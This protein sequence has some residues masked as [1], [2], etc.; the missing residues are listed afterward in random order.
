MDYIP[1]LL[2]S[3]VWTFKGDSMT[4]KLGLPSNW[5]KWASVSVLISCLCLASILGI[6]NVSGPSD[7]VHPDSPASASGEPTL[8]SIRGDNDHRIIP[9]EDVQVGDRVEGTNPLREQVE[10]LE[11][12]AASWRKLKL[13]MEKEGGSSLSIDLLRSLE[14]IKQ[15]QATVGSTIY[16]ELPEM[17]AVGD[18]TVTYLGPCPRIKPGKGTPVTGKFKHRADADSGVVKLRLE[19]QEQATGVTANH[20]YWSVKRRAFAPVGQLREGEIVD[21]VLGE[22]RVVSITPV[23]Y[24]GFLYNLETLEHVFRVDSLGTLVHNTCIHATFG[25]GK[26]IDEFTDLM[27]SKVGKSVESFP[28]MSLTK[29][30]DEM[31]QGTRRAMDDAGE[32][33]FSLKGMEKGHFQDFVRGG[34]HK[35]D[36]YP[37]A[38]NVTDRELY[39]VLT[40]E[41]LLKKATFYDELGN[42]INAPLQWLDLL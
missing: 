19:G 37:G 20:L 34:G 41:N 9:I 21:T 2:K 8:A 17:G 26:H 22:R 23:E 39:E 24:T 11:L 13:H 15:Q 38:S 6:K 42:V 7:D 5:R 30:T 27:R 3:P 25:I 18:A 4:T 14:W 28:F 40:D 36:P 29:S 10:D 33:H 32:I 31:W 16:L 1:W 12:D 35:F